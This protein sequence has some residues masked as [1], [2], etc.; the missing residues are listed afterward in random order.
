M[1]QVSGDA[2]T[3][4]QMAITMEPEGG[5]ETPTTSPVMQGNLTA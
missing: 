2:S 5:S 4:G 1:V 3:A